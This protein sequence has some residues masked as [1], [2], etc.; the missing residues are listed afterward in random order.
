MSAVRPDSFRANADEGNR[1]Q[2]DQ[3]REVLTD[4]PPRR[5]ELRNVVVKYPFERS[6]RFP[7]SSNTGPT[8]MWCCASPMHRSSHDHTVALKVFVFAHSG[9]SS[10]AMRLGSRRSARYKVHRYRI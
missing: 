4:K 1:I 7:G 5:L 9:T 2:F 10:D 8:R 6:V 3:K